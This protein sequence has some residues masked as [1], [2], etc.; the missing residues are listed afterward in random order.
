MRRTN[1]GA[2]ALEGWCT[3]DRNVAYG[4]C[5]LRA[6]GRCD[7]DAKTYC[8]DVVLKVVYGAIR[9]DGVVLW[10][11]GLTLSGY[12]KVVFV[13]C[14]RNCVIKMLDGYARRR[15]IGRYGRL[16]S[17]ECIQVEKFPLFVPLPVIWVFRLH[18]RAHEVCATQAPMHVLC[19]SARCYAWL[20]TTMMMIAE[21]V[22]DCQ[23][24]TVLPLKY[25]QPRRRS[26][27]I[28][29][30]HNASITRP[31]NPP[32]YSRTGGMQGYQVQYCTQGPLSVC[33]SSD[34][35]VCDSSVATCPALRLCH[36]S[37]VGQCWWCAMRNVRKGKKAVEDS[38]YVLPR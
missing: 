25:K 18:L 11:K 33:G 30:T 12:F 3:V 24:A 8:L 19:G 31:G 5:S 20:Q 9:R 35:L 22:A 21:V 26:S 23:L 28:L 17:S 37:K 14:G 29:E 13:L 1:W 7:K 2:G 15:P 4:S 34:A 27:G 32:G 6:G 10:E 38:P 16:D 36:F